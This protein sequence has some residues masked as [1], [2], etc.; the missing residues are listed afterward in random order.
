MHQWMRD[1]NQFAE[2]GKQGKAKQLT[3]S[4]Q[5]FQGHQR[6]GFLDVGNWPLRRSQDWRHQIPQKVELRCEAATGA[7][8]KR[9]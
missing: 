3:K 7:L 4:K 2:G 9:L 1:V 8:D 6:D 5:K